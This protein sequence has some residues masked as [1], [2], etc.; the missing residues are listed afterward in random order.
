MIEANRRLLGRLIVAMLSLTALP[1]W[2]QPCYRVTPILPPSPKQGIVM[3]IALNDRGEVTGGLRTQ[4]DIIFVW[5]EQDG[6]HALPILPRGNDSFGCYAHAINNAGQVVGNCGVAVQGDVQHGLSVL[7]NDPRGTPSDG[8]SI[9]FAGKIVGHRAALNGGYEAFLYD[10][11]CGMHALMPHD[12]EASVFASFINASGL[13]IGFDSTHHVPFV[14][15][16][17][18]G[19]RYLD[20]AADTGERAY[21]SALN[22]SGIVLLDVWREVI[23]TADDPR[24]V[25]Y[26]QGFDHL[27]P[28]G[29]AAEAARPP[30]RI[31]RHAYL[32]DIGSGQRS[33]IGHLPGG[34]EYTRGLQINRHRE[35]VGES[36]ASDNAMRAFYWHPYTG[37]LQVDQLIDRRD[38]YDGIAFHSALGIND[39]GQ[40]LAISTDGKPFLLT[41]VETGECPVHRTSSNK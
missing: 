3:P 37:M 8:W 9:N 38:P 7:E 40:I 24:R 31:E 17:D 1:A 5:S 39:V 6:M 15:S 30:F 35:V 26:G 34:D 16:P 19:V 28:E 22:D 25:D 33:P 27:T 12:P 4:R 13:V 36:G 21:A 2:P 23:T 20:A 29:V 32:Y 14:W 11:C 10:S 41:P 18:Y